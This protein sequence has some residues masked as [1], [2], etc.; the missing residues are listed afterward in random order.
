M[1][2]AFARSDS[3]NKDVS[4]NPRFME[5]FKTQTGM[6]ELLDDFD[7]IGL[8]E[9]Q[10]KPRMSATN[11]ARKPINF[12]ANE[13][14]SA[15]TFSNERPATQ[16]QRPAEMRQE[17]LIRKNFKAPNQSFESA[18]QEPK[19]SF[20]MKIKKNPGMSKAG[21]TLNSFSF[22]GHSTYQ[23]KTNIQPTKEEIN[24]WDWD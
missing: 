20:N 19:T 11:K 1:I 5:S 22:K 4:P 2:P 13:E 15:Q 16:A 21:M 10:I 17:G 12:Q 18:N 7:K 9:V 8:N 14:I 6:M 23:E 3:L 24:N